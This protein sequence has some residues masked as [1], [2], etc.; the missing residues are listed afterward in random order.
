ME[1]I[2]GENDRQWLQ[3]TIFRYVKGFG[4]GVYYSFIFL[5]ILNVS[6]PVVYIC[7]VH[8]AMGGTLIYVKMF[9]AKINRIMPNRI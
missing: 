5:K 6:T 2:A 3:E 9:R 4:I 7:Y 1:L 8:M